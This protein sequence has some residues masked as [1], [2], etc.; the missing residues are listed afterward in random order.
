MEKDQLNL[1][2]TINTPKRTRDED[3]ISP[4]S[5]QKTKERVIDMGSMTDEQFNK[6]ME[7]LHEIN[8]SQKSLEDEVS[9][10]RKENADFKRSMSEIRNRV[11]EVEDKIK[12]LDAANEESLG[13]VKLQLS[14][15]EAQ[16]NMLQQIQ[17]NNKV[18][19][20]NLP[21]HVRGESEKVKK[22]MQNILN[23]LQLDIQP[24]DYDAYAIE[25]KNKEMAKINVKFES[26]RMKKLFMEKLRA[27][28]REK[29]QPH[30]LVEK[31]IEIPEDHP[32]NGRKITATNH[33]TVYNF[34]L[35][36]Y[37]RK[38]V[39]SHF[40]F[41]FDNDDGIIKVKVGQK[42]IQIASAE[43]VDK[44]VSNVEAE[45]L[46]K[47]RKNN[48]PSTTRVTRNSASSVA[49]NQD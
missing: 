33:L 9:E 8:A 25:C 36:E 5:V 21:K 28:K 19:I 35:L 15:L 10:I 7:T 13:E 37:A 48:I 6:I 42:F 29:S 20:H 1:I 39:P 47:N 24:K 49:M 45:K 3:S 34:K 2:S 18:T 26:T 14:S 32:L 23:D 4:E 44:L 27:C 40:Q 17:L 38:F 11:R 30:L 43:D 12:T 16:N 31:I 46:K 22:V 41:A